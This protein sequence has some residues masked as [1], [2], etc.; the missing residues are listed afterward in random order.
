ML[1]VGNSLLPPLSQLT[2][3]GGFHLFRWVGGC[4]PVA[5]TQGYQM[6]CIWGSLVAKFQGDGEVLKCLVFAGLWIC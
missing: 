5:Q 6:V 4:E 2:F 3:L 1:E